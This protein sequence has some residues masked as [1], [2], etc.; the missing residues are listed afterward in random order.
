MRAVKACCIALQPSHLQIQWSSRCLGA[1]EVE[2]GVTA[3]T[4]D[5]FEGVI[6]I[7]F[8][9]FFVQ[10]RRL[11]RSRVPQIESRLLT[12][13][14]LC[15]T[16]NVRALSPSNAVCP[17]FLPFSGQKLQ[18]WREEHNIMCMNHYSIT[19]AIMSKCN[20]AVVL[21]FIDSDAVSLWS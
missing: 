11:K 1:I 14:V 3:A 13:W 18:K 6:L 16:A 20:S 9:V 10:G 8:A 4:A 2:E 19:I 7:V 21:S 15:D 12:N 17:C 5:L